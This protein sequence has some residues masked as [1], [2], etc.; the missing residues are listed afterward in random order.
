MYPLFS[1]ATA[2]ARS[3]H[4][5]IL[6]RPCASF[7]SVTTSSSSASL[8]STYALSIEKCLK[9]RPVAEAVGIDIDELK[10][11]ANGLWSLHDNFQDGESRPSD[12]DGDIWGED[13][14]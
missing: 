8:F 5:G 4:P 3:N 6:T 9:R 2:A 7:S 11:L 1:V 10:E 12:P 13:E 14:E